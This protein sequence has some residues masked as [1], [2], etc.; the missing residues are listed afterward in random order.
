MDGVTLSEAMHNR[1]INI[2]Y[3]GKVTYLL[4]KVKQLEYLHSIAVGELVLRSAKH[5]FTAYLQSCEMMNL[6]VAVA[7]FLNCFFY[8]GLV[9]ANQLQND[10]VSHQRHWLQQAPNLE[11][12]SRVRTTRNETKEEDEPIR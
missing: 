1:G 3:L 11:I 12:S 2:R 9:A 5:I 10:E 4:S 7:H 8:S 6:S